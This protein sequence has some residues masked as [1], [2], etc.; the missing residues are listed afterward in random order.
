MIDS[1]M[2]RI[3]SHLVSVIIPTYNEEKD[4][5][6]CLKSLLAQNYHNIEIIVVDD[7]STDDTRSKIYDLGFKEIK[8]FEQKHFGPAIARNLGANRAKGEILVFVDADMTFDKNFIE[9]LIEPIIEGKTIG[10]FSKEEYVSNWNNVWSRC[11]N[12]NKNL[13]KNEMHPD[14]YPDIQD[15]FRAILKSK[16]EEV[17][18]F[19]SVGYNDDWTLAKKLDIQAVNAPGAIFFHQNPDTLTEVWQQ[20]S[21]IGKRKYKLRLVALARASLPMSILIGL[22]KSIYYKNLYFIIF[23][24]IFDLAISISILKSFLPG[25]SVVK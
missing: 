4:I 12:I 9:N 8:V 20:A 2:K 11:W 24:M 14:N 22:I 17:G 13:S 7:G 3:I 10:T 1:L 16:F 21:W 19:D 23:K 6:N 25:Y 15:V 5:S 18:G